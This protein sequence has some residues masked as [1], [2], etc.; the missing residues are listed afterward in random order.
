MVQ[1]PGALGVALDTSDDVY[2]TDGASVYE[3]PLTGSAYGAPATLFG[4]VRAAPVSESLV[5]DGAGNLIAPVPTNDGIGVF[6]PGATAPLYV[7]GSGLLSQPWYFAHDQSQHFLYVCAAHTEGMYI[8]RY[9]DGTAV[10]AFLG[11]RWNQPWRPGDR[12]G[13]GYRAALGAAA[14]RHAV[15]EQPQM[16]SRAIAFIV[17]PPRRRTSCCAPV[18]R[19]A[20]T[21]PAA[22]TPRSA[23]HLIRQ[24]AAPVNWPQ[25]AADASHD[26]F[27]RHEKLIG[28]NNV[29]SLQSR[30]G[31]S[32][33]DREML[34]RA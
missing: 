27:N 12:A 34:L 4:G 32:R 7:I 33:P 19:A 15:T 22:V 5:L 21:Q 13:R 31:H 10:A 9:P 18:A 26:G 14:E 24:A 2:Y 6:P 1:A 3:L 25:F 23:A 8:F 29:A 30:R 17:A 11:R 16:I 20:A 28:P